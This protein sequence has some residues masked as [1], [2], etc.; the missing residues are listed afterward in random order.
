MTIFD[1]IIIRHATPEDFD[2]MAE[3]IALIFSVEEDFTADLAK[4]RKG[5]EMFQ[6]NPHGRCLV[7]AERH[8][9]V[10]GMC[11]GQLLI[12]TAE[13]GWKAIV[14]DVVVAEKFRGAGIGKRM[15]S[16]LADWAVE[17]GAKRLDLL[18]DRNNDKG[19]RF[20]QKT[21]WRHTNLIALQ[22]HI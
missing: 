7:V 12:S 10:I 18:A 4:Q 1:H 11:S 6:A 22:K 20:Y 19:I 16:A 17:Q 3:L 9:K 14:E 15:L 13:G 2:S 21:H 5:L 8:S